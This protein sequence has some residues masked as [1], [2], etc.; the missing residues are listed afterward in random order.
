MEYARIDGATFLRWYF[1]PE[2]ITF[3]LSGDAT[4]SEL[5]ML[6][7][8]LTNPAWNVRGKFGGPTF[9]VYDE[10]DLNAV[11]QFVLDRLDID[12]EQRTHLLNNPK[13]VS[14]QILGGDEPLQ[15]SPIGS[16][17]SV[18]S[19]VTRA[20][21]VESAEDQIERARRLMEVLTR[22]Q[23]AL[24]RET[25][26]AAYGGRCAI[27]GCD[28]TDV[29]QAAHIQ[30]VYDGGTDN[31]SNG[32]LLR[33]DI[34]RLFD[35]GHVA[36]DHEAMTVLVSP[37]LRGSEYENLAGKPIRVPSEEQNRPRRFSL[38][39]HRISTGL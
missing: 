29:L 35:L 30:P 14:P 5:S 24:F 4:G 26:L 12:G 2:Y 16:N 10:S 25:L 34:H 3:F 33:V 20:A 23:Q 27:T 13:S 15:V 21:H 9:R 17:S 6:R 36:I 22:P 8:G 7:R 39:R 19:A 28:V 37:R 11:K 1:A 32:L 31:P 18:S 38:L